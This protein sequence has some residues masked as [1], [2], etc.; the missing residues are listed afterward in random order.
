MT[1]GTLVGAGDA[2]E[3]NFL[4]FSPP[5]MEQWKDDRKSLAFM[6]Y[7]GGRAVCIAAV[8]H[9]FVLCPFHT[10]GFVIK[11]FQILGIYS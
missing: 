1:A 11:L 6:V 4:T 7:P 3:R 5:P 2:G 10:V 8:F 9:F